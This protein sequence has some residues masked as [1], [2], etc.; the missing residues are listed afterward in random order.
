ML[1]SKLNHHQLSAV[2]PAQS[3]NLLSVEV[4]KV[5]FVNVMS[6]VDPLL[7]RITKCVFEVVSA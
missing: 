2:R 6:M 4:L 3:A 1:I 7:L 5:I